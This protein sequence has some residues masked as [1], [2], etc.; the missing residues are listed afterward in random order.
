MTESTFIFSRWA[1]WTAQR[2]QR[3]CAQCTRKL[4]ESTSF[5]GNRIEKLVVFSS[6]RTRER[7]HHRFFFWVLNIEW[8]IYA[9]LPL[10]VLIYSICSSVAMLLRSC[11]RL[12]GIAFHVRFYPE[13]LNV[14]NWIYQ[15]SWSMHTYSWSSS[16]AQHTQHTQFISLFHVDGA[17]SH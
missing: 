13:T 8:I 3:V 9:N 1:E 5:I 4:Y 10:C 14:N 12:N 15:W 16:P 11:H 7:E 2:A 17:V 6:A